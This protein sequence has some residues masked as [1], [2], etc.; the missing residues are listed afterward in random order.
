MGMDFYSNEIFSPSNLDTLWNLW[1]LSYNSLTLE[2]KIY[3]N[4]IVVVQDIAPSSYSGNLDLIVGADGGGTSSAN[5]FFN[6]NIDNFSIWDYPLSDLEIQQYS[7]CG[8]N[9]NES[10]LVGYWNF[11]EGSGST[12]LDLT[13]NGNDGI[14]NGA[15]YD[16][17]VPS[18]S[19]GL[20]NANGCDSTAVLNLTINQSDTSYTNITACD[21]VVWNGETYTESGTYSYLELNNNEFSMSFDGNDDYLDLTLSVNNDFSFVGWVYHNQFQ[22]GNNYILESPS[23][24][25]IR[26]SGHGCNSTNNQTTQ[27]V[28]GMNGQ[29]TNHCGNT[30][31]NANEWIHVAVTQHQDSVRFY[32]NGQLDAVLYEP[33]TSS[34]IFS[35]L[36]G[37]PNN[38]VWNGEMDEVSFWNTSLSQQ[39]I[40]Q[41]MNCSL[42]GNELGLVGYWSFEEGSGATVSDQSS[43]GNDGTIN[44]ATYDTNV[45]VQS[46]GLTNANGC[47]STAVLNLTIDN[48][49]STSNT[50]S[51]CSGDSFT[52]G[53]STYNTDGTY[54]DVL[55]TTDGCDS[56]VT[57][58][59]TLDPLGCTD[60]SSF[61]YDANAICDDGSCIAVV[62]GCTDP[63]AFN[64]DASANT[65]DG[66]CIAVV[67]GCIDPAAFNYDANANTDDGSCIAVINECTEQ[68]ANN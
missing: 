44:G 36:G 62:L 55:T 23:G 42:S 45:P 39:E 29:N 46:C 61:N 38:N 16:T 5:G 57:T 66:S 25:T 3:K 6:G 9:G 13:S 37:I 19:C 64:Y 17:S 1:V 26:L 12:A 54:T 15:T 14:I 49:V 63:A 27:W 20:T 2:R 47:D 60:A 41:Y 50:V 30:I 58:I 40:Q 11:E 4:G 48:S 22:N 67:L 32:I 43:N 33:S 18:Q 56:T 28:L 53:T 59:L 34:R 31:L 35:K 8:I 21:S 65:D 10:G 68:A 52:V 51:I 7:G 24:S